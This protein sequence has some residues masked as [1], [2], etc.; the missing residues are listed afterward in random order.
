LT[1]DESPRATWQKIT[2]EHEMRRM[3]SY[4]L[5]ISAASAYTIDQEG[6]TADEKETDIQL[7]AQSGQGAVIELKLGEK[8]SGRQLRDAIKDQLVVKYLAPEKRRA[9]C[10]LVTLGSDHRWDHPATG[11]R[12]DVDGLREM[13][14]ERAAFVEKDLGWS[15]RL[16]V[17]V[18]DLRSRFTPGA[19]KS[20]D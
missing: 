12:L 16:G 13:L 3:I 14:R 20:P 17:R 2:D 8:W 10:L 11:A 4:Q 1:R 9:G 7:R 19:A 18:L 15:V 5:K 6:V